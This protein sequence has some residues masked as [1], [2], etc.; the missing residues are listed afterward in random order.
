MINLFQ[1][2][3]AVTWVVGILTLVAGAIGVSNIM[4]IAVAERSREIAFA[5]RWSDAA[6]SSSRWSP[7]R[8]C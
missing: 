6:S 5:R 4:M 8:R 7:S 3:G 2:I 1:A